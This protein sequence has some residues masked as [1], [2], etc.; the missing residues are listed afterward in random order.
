MQHYGNISPIE[1]KGFME[2]LQVLTIVGSTVGSCWYFRRETKEQIAELKADAKERAQET[3]DFHGRMCALEERYIQ[4]M[5][6]VMERRKKNEET[7]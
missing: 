3:K 5:Q 2:W 1:T 7:K 6:R 4:M